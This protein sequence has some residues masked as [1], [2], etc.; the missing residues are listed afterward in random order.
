MNKLVLLCILLA[1]VSCKKD[2][3]SRTVEYR[4]SC[5]SCAVNYRSANGD[6]VRNVILD[7]VWHYAEDTTYTR[8][9]WAATEEIP[10]AV[11]P[12]LSLFNGTDNGQHDTCT[13][14]IRIDGSVVRSQ[15]ITSIA[16]TI[17]LRY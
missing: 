5:Y 16:G 4:A 13:A 8:A 3:Q 17:E 9:T 10:E 6:F 12:H 15:R 7:T 11:S 14:E 1:A 2:E